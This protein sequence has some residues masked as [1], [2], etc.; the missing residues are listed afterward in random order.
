VPFVC[1]CCCRC[2]APAPGAARITASTGTSANHCLRTSPPSK[3]L[4]KPRTVNGARQVSNPAG[5][6]V[7]MPYR[8]H[9]SKSVVTNH[10]LHA[11]L[12]QG[13]HALSRAEVHAV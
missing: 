5:G 12:S 13:M 3:Q 9:A 7:P 10:A 4:V 2:D 1:C 8:A 6:P 11:S